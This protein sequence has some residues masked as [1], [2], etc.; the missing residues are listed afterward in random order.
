MTIDFREQGYIQVFALQDLIQMRL[1]RVIAGSW[2]AIDV[3]K[4]QAGRMFP[5]LHVISTDN[6]PRSCR[7]EVWLERGV[8][9]LVRV[10]TEFRS[11]AGAP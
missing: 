11:S 2:R 3:L 7:A 6:V 4:N 8:G 9:S 1:L 10:V 5:F